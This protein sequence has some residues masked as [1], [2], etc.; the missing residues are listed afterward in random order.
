M[1]KTQEACRHLNFDGSNHQWKFTW[2][3][4]NDTLQNLEDYKNQVLRKKKNQSNQGKQGI[5]NIFSY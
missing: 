2:I 5:E 1:K 3:L 4:K